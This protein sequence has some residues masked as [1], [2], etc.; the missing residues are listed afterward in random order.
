LEQNRVST[1]YGERAT[2]SFTLL[3]AKVAFQLS[4]SASITAGVNNLFD[5]NYYEHLS[6]SVR[7]NNLPI[8]A[9]GRNAF[10]SVNFVF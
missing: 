8:F 4:K 1:E 9:P 6:R 7:G 3:D 5:E 2:P 10:A